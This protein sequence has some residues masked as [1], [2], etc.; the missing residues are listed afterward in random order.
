VGKDLGN[1]S[2]LKSTQLCFLIVIVQEETFF[3]DERKNK[4]KINTT[5][6]EMMKVNSVVFWFHF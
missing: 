3:R 1:E 2:I 5:Q 6:V 4:K